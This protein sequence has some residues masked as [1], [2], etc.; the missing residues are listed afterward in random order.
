MRSIALPVTLSL[1][2]VYVAA[3]GVERSEVPSFSRV[4]AEQA[5]AAVAALKILPAGLVP[6]A[7]VGTLISADLSTSM[8]RQSLAPVVEALAGKDAGVARN[9]RDALIKASRG[10][11]ERALRLH[12]RIDTRLHRLKTP[13]EGDAE[14]LEV[15]SRQLGELLADQADYMA[16]HDILDLTD[17]MAAA[18]KG[19]G[20][21]RAARVMA[22]AR[23]TADALN[24]RKEAEPVA[25][26]TSGSGRASLRP[27]LERGAQEQSPREVPAP[28]AS[29]VSAPSA[30][31]PGA[32]A[33]YVG[34]ALVVAG[35]FDYVW[36]FG[37]DYSRML[38][39]MLMAVG[40]SMI[41]VAVL[42]RKPA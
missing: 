39:M 37:S 12:L 14:V 4:T 21:L 36:R 5:G 10:V 16:V 31:T 15:L 13:K 27:S 24:P 40:L 23:P 38:P 9:V 29:A 28:A 41:L 34:G 20:E 2:S 17:A 26:E 7:L 11:R 6:G 32:Y 1:L 22:S 3:G 30:K 19:A 42:R 33:A 25:G 35:V 8:G 18:T